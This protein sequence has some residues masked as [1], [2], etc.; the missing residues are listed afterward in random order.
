MFDYFNCSFDIGSK[1][2]QIIFDSDNVS[3]EN[4]TEA[5]EHAN[6]Q[7]LSGLKWC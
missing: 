4:I 1:V 3:K 7:W 6:N 2:V 5:L